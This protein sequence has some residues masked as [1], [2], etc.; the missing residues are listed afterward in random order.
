M[1]ANIMLEIVSKLYTSLT[2]AEL[3]Q[4]TTETLSAPL[5]RVLKT[6]LSVELSNSKLL[7]ELHKKSQIVWSTICSQ[8]NLYWEKNNT[9]EVLRILSPLLVS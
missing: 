6:V 9:N 8:F 3:L 1:S 5:S 2:S 7:R 4:H